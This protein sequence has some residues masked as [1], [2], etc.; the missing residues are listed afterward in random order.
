MPGGTAA[1]TSCKAAQPWRAE[2]LEEG[3]V[4]L[5]GQGAGGGG[6]D[7]AQAEVARG[8][9]GRRGQVGGVRV[10]AH[11]QQRTD[12]PGAGVEQVKE[13]RCHGMWILIIGDYFLCRYATQK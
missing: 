10:K 12:L 8:G 3:G 6:F 1:M 5:I 11:A 13:R 2:G 4:G 7:Q 9:G